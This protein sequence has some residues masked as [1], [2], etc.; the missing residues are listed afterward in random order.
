VA[1]IKA[2]MLLKYLESI[3]NVHS[4]VMLVS[5]VTVMSF[6]FPFPTGI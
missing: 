3:I 2:L 6:F 1:E 5:I 4:V